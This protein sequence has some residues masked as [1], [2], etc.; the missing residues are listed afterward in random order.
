[1]KNEVKL[2]IIK[3]IHTVVWGFFVVVIGYVLYCG[4]ANRI[5][6]RTW[7][8]SALVVGEG[9]VLLLGQ[10]HCPLTLLARRYSAST[11]DNFDIFLPNWLARYNQ[12][13]FTSIYGFALLLLA[14][15]LVLGR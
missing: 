12:L 2:L 4:L 6:W 3:I 11:Q 13:I 1:M 15:R 14:C 10:R 7:V 5:T 9:V 8:A